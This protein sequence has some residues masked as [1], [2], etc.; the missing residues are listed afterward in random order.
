MESTHSC[1]SCNKSKTC[2]KRAVYTKV[3]L[4][5]NVCTGE[6]FPQFEKYDINLQHYRCAFLEFS[7]PCSREIPA[8]PFQMSYLI[9]SQL[10]R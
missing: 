7:S 5:C 2:V 10:R 9:L 8:D 6:V 1:F 4:L 3:E